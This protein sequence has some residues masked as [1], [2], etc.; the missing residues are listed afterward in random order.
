MRTTRKENERTGL[1]MSVGALSQTVTEPLGKK[2][3][4]VTTTQEVRRRKMMRKAVPE[5]AVREWLVLP[6]LYQ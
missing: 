4:G 5:E 2:K 6:E 3:L 1:E